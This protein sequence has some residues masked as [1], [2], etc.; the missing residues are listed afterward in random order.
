M[1]TIIKTEKSFLNVYKD[2]S[3]EYND[4]MELCIAEI[5]DKFLENPKINI[6]GKTAIQH[7][8]IGFFSNDSIGYYYSGQL[9]KS[10]SLSDN[11]SI[12]LEKI[13]TKFG[14]KFNGILVNKYNDGNDYIGA[15][16]DDETALDK[17][18]VVCISYGAIRKFRIKNKITKKTVVDIPTISNNIL[19][20]GGDF[21][22]EFTHEIPIEKKIKN[23]RYSFT[24]RKHNK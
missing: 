7:R 23:V 24:F 10:Q 5:M 17:C 12:L 18:G 13:N 21:Q 3:E 2:S 1:N 9:A 22:K 19:H 8:S 11:L 14:S 20:M 15:H 6:Y 16:S 4:L